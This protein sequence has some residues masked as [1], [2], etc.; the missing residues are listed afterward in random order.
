MKDLTQFGKLL[1]AA[2]AIRKA[3]IEYENALAEFNRISDPDSNLLT[4]KPTH[5]K[6]DGRRYALEYNGKEIKSVEVSYGTG[7]A[8]NYDRMLDPKKLITLKVEIA[9]ELPEDSIPHFEPW[10]CF[11][12]IKQIIDDARETRYAV[13]KTFNPVAI[14]VLNNI[15]MASNYSVYSPYNLNVLIEI[16]SRFKSDVTGGIGANPIEEALDQ[17]DNSAQDII[18]AY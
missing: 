13:I 6:K 3:E 2:K 16:D 1:E 9:P 12:R 4:L 5:V 10:K 7:A 17:V 11:Q 14:D 15:V 18:N 8:T